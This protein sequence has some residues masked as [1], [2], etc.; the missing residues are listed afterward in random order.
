MINVRAR[1]LRVKTSAEK[2]ALEAQLKQVGEAERMVQ[3]KL[4]HATSGVVCPSGVLQEKSPG[5]A[6]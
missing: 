4:V 3:H 1:D 5:A 6:L 2:N